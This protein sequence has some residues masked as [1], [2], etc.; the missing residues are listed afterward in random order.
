[1]VRRR[2]PAAMIAPTAPATRS[3]DAEEATMSPEIGVLLVLL[4]LLVVAVASIRFGVDSRD[5]DPRGR[6]RPAL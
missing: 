6:S 1:M 4:L 5:L 2:P 3:A